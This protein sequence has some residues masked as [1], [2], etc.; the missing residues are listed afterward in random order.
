MKAELKKTYR[1]LVLELHPDRG[2]SHENMVVL[3]EVWDE[4]VKRRGRTKTA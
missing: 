4:I 2:G 1:G 3:N